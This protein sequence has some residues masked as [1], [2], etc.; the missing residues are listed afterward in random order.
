MRSGRESAVAIK[1]A[2]TSQLDAGTLRTVRALLDDVFGPG[3]TDDAWDHALGGM[4]ALVWEAGQLVAHGSV[5]QRRLLHQ[6][7]AL[8]AGYVEAVAVRA[9]RRGCGYGARVMDA[10][11]PVIRD[12]YDIG[13]LG[14]TEMGG[15]FYRRRGWRPWE[16]RTWA[17]APSGLTRTA[18]RDES[19]HVLEVGVALD[20]SGD[21]TCDWRE[22]DVW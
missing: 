17:L 11:E 22:G 21:L 6:G 18:D 19:V 4:H 10:L 13:A 5:V 1:L 15:G 8:R 7:R 12:A 9:D 20:V 2:H 14:A 16:G 3:M